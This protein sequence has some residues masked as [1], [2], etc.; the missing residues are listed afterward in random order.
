MLEH[1]FIQANDL[2]TLENEVNKFIK[3]NQ[4]FD[5]KLVSFAPM[6]AGGK[7]QN[8]YY[9]AVMSKT[10]SA[11]TRRTRDPLCPSA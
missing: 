5:P 8:L 4:K 3:D 9:F 11:V 2:S 6:T 10:T 7:W 1:K